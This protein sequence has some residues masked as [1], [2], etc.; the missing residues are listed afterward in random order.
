MT[1]NDK[2]QPEIPPEAIIVAGNITGDGEVIQPL[3]AALERAQAR[4]SQKG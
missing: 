1:D 3:K 2:L 4:R